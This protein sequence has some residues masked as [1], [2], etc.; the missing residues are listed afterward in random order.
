M[1]AESEDLL[2]ALLN[3]L[4]RHTEVVQGY[5]PDG[6]HP[7]LWYGAAADAP[8]VLRVTLE[9]RPDLRTWQYALS[10]KWPHPGKAATLDFSWVRLFAEETY[11]RPDWRATDWNDRAHTLATMDLRYKRI[12]DALSALDMAL[13]NRHNL[14][15]AV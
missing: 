9:R 6:D 12:E 4:G 1:E 8:D 15:R 7:R 3:I 13:L 2:D 10:L 14:W 5:D 11:A